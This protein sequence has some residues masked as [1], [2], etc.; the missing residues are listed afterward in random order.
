MAEN[1]GDLNL[2]VSV[3]SRIIADALPA[4]TTVS[5][6]TRKAIAKAASV[7]VLYATA[8]AAA[9]AAKRNR[10]TTFA[11]D[12]LEGIVEMEFSQFSGPLKKSLENYQQ[13]VK[14]KPKPAKKSE[15]FDDTVASSS[16]PKSAKLKKS[17]PA[18]AVELVEISEESD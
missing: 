13:N 18:A 2:P 4:G 16:T 6:E 9:M 10:K 15:D 7:F 3:V 11:S 8:S 12:V 5:V 17:A 14:K 1:P